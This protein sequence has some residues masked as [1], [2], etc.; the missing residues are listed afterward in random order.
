MCKTH[1]GSQGVILE[2]LLSKKIK[3]ILIELEPPLPFMENSIENFHFIF[4]MTSL[5]QNVCNCLKLK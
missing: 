5:I 3:K 4:R 2:W 1:F